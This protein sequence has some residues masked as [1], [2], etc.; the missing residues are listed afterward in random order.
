MRV[1]AL[2][3]LAGCAPSADH[4]PVATAGVLDLGAWRAEDGPAMLA[5]EWDLLWDKLD[6][7]TRAPAPD[8]FPVRGN[9]GGHHLTDGRV[10]PGQGFATLRLR[11][12]LPAAMRGSDLVISL[13]DCGTACRL[14]V[15]DERGA[16]LARAARIGTVADTP[17]RAVPERGRD[18]V[19]FTAPGEL[20]VYFLISNFH[21][22]RGGAWEPPILGDAEAVGALLRRTERVD[23]VVFGLLLMMGVYQLLRF[24]MR[25]AERAPLWFGLLCLATA[26][27]SLTTGRYVRWEFGSSL[28]IEYLTFY[29]G[30][31]LAALLARSLGLL[32]RWLARAGVVTCVGFCLAVVVLPPSLFT[33]TMVP[34]QILTAALIGWLVIDLVR[35]VVRTP[36]APTLLLLSGFVSLC[37]GAVLDML[38]THHV[39][40]GGPL[41]HFGLGAFVL[42]QACSLALFEER[43]RRGEERH[44]REVVALNQLLQQRVQERS[45]EL[46]AALEQLTA[47]TPDGLAPG[48]VL[49]ER[50]ELHEPIGAGGAGT[51]YR[52]RDRVTAQEVAVKILHPGLGADPL[53]RFVSEAA[54]TSV[55]PDPRI[56]RTLHVDVAPD[57]RAYQIMELVRGVDLEARLR[58]GGFRPGHAARIGQ[59]LAE[60]LSAAH[61]AGVV[62]RD[63]KPAN[64]MLC[65]EAP[66]VRLLDFGISKLPA[67]ITP[68]GMTRQQALGTPR[69]MAPEQAVPSAEVTPATDVYALALVLHEMIA[70]ELPLHAASSAQM[71]WASVAGPELSERIRPPGLCALLVRCLD[72]QATRRPAADEVAAGLRVVADAEGAPPAALAWQDVVEDDRAAS[73]T[74]KTM[75]L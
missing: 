16:A 59:E 19:R 36:D 15:R 28:A 68:P 43:T 71:M 29:G 72:R 73:P 41:F 33:R 45:R 70:G 52:G 30:V 65:A 23:F 62:H 22:G 57:G 42:I 9:F 2:I 50:V 74:A 49:D 26:M 4:A 61:R 56:V 11:V 8:H 17:S 38:G 39:T 12:R 64:V 32:P 48:T 20:W 14:L 44:A 35:A 3:L 18:S 66:G 67:S 13:R 25:P 31:A 7:E 75:Q 24:G 63:V 34:F 10:L 27:R 54:A 40:S 47:V 58:Q 55:V 5:G 69:Y 51:V 1:L 37:G 60:V 6:D 21:H 46:R 53:R